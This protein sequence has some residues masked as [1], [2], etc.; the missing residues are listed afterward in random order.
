MAFEKKTWVDEDTASDTDPRLEATE[1][2]RFEKGIANAFSLGSTADGTPYTQ[3][4]TGIIYIDSCASTDLIY[5]GRYYVNTLTDSPSG[6]GGFVD[7]FVR[8]AGIINL[9]YRDFRGHTS[10]EQDLYNST[11]TDWVLTSGQVTLYNSTT[12]VGQSGTFTTSQYLG[13]F[14]SVRIV[15]SGNQAY[16]VEGKVNTNTDGNY[17]VRASVT[18]TDT[19]GNSIVQVAV[20]SFGTD[21]SVLSVTNARSSRQI[22]TAAGAATKTDLNIVKVIGL[23]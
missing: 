20:L 6:Q 1:L 15:L 17:N 14:G 9:K 12:G 3:N 4:A 2:N 23:P 18:D 10:W 21:S 8:N 5:T 22:R 11:W 7:T 13:R 16:G 19:L